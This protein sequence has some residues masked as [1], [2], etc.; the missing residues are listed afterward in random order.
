MRIYATKPGK[1]ASPGHSSSCFATLNHR[2]VLLYLL[3]SPRLIHLPA[4]I[5]VM[6]L[7]SLW[8]CYAG[9]PQ[10]LDQPASGGFVFS[11][12]SNHK[13]SPRSN[14]AHAAFA[15]GEVRGRP[16]KGSVGIG[17]YS[18]RQSLPAKQWRW[19]LRPYSTRCPR[20]QQYQDLVRTVKNRS[21]FWRQLPVIYL[22]AA[23][24]Y[25]RGLRRIA[26]QIPF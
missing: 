17:R 15:L 8:S 24:S 5:L 7:G 21:R 23:Q 6:T 11:A 19:R 1:S 18:A 16:G 25:A 2:T 9:P 10:S 20:K 4:T 12:A 3:C 13:A 14:A 22:G 26:S